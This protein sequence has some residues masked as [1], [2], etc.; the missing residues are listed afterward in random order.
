MLSLHPVRSLKSPTVLIHSTY[1]NQR[2]YKSR[3]PPRRLVARFAHKS[4]MSIRTIWG[5]AQHPQQVCLSA[6]LLSLQTPDSLK[7]SLTRKW[8]MGNVIEICVC[9]SRKT[10]INRLRRTRSQNRTQ[11]FGFQIKSKFKMKTALVF[12]TVSLIFANALTTCKLGPGR[13]GP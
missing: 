12:D 8:E 4:E 10:R 9:H 11:N 2:G 5:P 3:Y 7:S 1:V 6:W 13:F